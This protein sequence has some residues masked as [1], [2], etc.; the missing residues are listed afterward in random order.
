MESYDH[1]QGIC[2][3]RQHGIESLISLGDLKFS[4]QSCVN[5]D[6]SQGHEIENHI[7]KYPTKGASFSPELFLSHPN[8]NQL[9]CGY[10]SQF[11]HH[12]PRI[13]SSN[14]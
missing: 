4:D 8:I 14:M 12:G 3:H 6:S 1:L 13:I 10:G 11:G 2:L 7:P 5:R 9:K